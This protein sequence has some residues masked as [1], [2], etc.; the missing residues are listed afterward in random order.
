M[1]R[2][3]NSFDKKMEYDPQ[4]LSDAQ[5]ASDYQETASI[6]T[7]YMAKATQAIQAPA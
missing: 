5:I 3:L 1:P 7:P 4:K 6:D 2:A